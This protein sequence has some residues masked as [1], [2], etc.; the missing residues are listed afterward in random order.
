MGIWKVSPPFNSDS[1]YWSK[2]AWERKCLWIKSSKS[3]NSV[4]YS[5][6]KC[7]KTHRESLQ[8]KV[9]LKKMIPSCRWPADRHLRLNRLEK[10]CRNAIMWWCCLWTFSYRN[11][12]VLPSYR[13]AE[14]CKHSILKEKTN[15]TNNTARP[16][17]QDVLLPGAFQDKYNG[18]VMTKTS[19]FLDCK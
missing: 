6:S 2:G 1:P 16:F 18:L 19:Y 15:H 13:A 7:R 3:W 17:V 8:P 14:S 12:L 9:G 11:K 5:F 10:K 4:C